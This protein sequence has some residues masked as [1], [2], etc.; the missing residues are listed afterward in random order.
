M[1][2]SLFICSL[3]VHGRVVGGENVYF[4][5]LRFL[6]LFS[7]ILPTNRYRSYVQTQN[8][9]QNASFLGFM[10]LKQNNMVC[11]HVHESAVFKTTEA[12]LCNKYGAIAKICRSRVTH[13]VFDLDLR[14][15]TGML[16]NTFNCFPWVSCVKLISICRVIVLD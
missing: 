12:C 6:K 14:N 2:S 13:K 9:V 1:L 11:I 5:K 10:Y 8:I 4:F 7:W 16:V 15:F 3:S